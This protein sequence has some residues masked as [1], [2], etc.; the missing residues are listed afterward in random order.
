[1]PV[2][3]GV[4]AT[5][6]ILQQSAAAVTSPAPDPDPALQSE[7][8]STRHN[9]SGGGPMPGRAGLRRPKIVAL[10]A[11]HASSEDLDEDAVSLFDAWL[12]KPTTR[13][14][15]RQMLNNVLGC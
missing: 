1:M 15:M 12:T 8:V 3:D 5:R 4:R 14:D 11:S 2:M 6:L 7:L 13:E 9:N 10:S